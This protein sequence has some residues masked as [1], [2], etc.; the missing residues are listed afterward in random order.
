MLLEMV[1]GVDALAAKA[2]WSISRLCS[3]LVNEVSVGA[4]PSS[5]LLM[6]DVAD[7]GCRGCVI[8]VPVCSIFGLPG[9]VNVAL[10]VDASPS[11]E[12]LVD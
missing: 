7:A 3:S 12:S 11:N 2:G 9:G 8:N 5:K 1:D 4:S 6:D 10:S